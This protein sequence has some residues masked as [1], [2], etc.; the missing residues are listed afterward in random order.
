[1]EKPKFIKRNLG[2]EDLP[3]S[4][5]YL[6][7][8]KETEE[9]HTIGYAHLEQLPFSC[10]DVVFGGKIAVS[11]TINSRG[12]DG[13]KIIKSH[14]IALLENPEQ[15]N[16]GEFLGADGELEGTPIRLTALTPESIRVLRLALDRYEAL[17]EEMP[18][19]SEFDREKFLEIQ[20]RFL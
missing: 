17:Q 16:P 11:A 5:I 15:R 8:V 19:G 1:M 9:G 20:R 7:T 10:V 2:F 18:V 6:R 3:G 13:P 4:G 14:Y 12:G